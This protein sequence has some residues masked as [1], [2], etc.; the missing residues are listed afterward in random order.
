[1]ILHC[2][3]DGSCPENAK[4]CLTPGGWAFIV[5]MPD[6]NVERAGYVP[7][8]TNNTMELQAVL[9]CLKY[10]VQNDLKHHTINIWCDSR[11]VVDGM[12]LWRHHWERDDFAGVKNAELWRWLHY[13][14]NKFRSV[15]LRWLKGHVGHFY[16]ERCDA[17]AGNAVKY[18]KRKTGDFT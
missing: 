17:L 10:L 15:R 14:A 9:E 11:Y 2:Y 13:H 16:N 8:A 5:I 3:T 18:G 12:E 7:H 1:M 4:G 6:Y